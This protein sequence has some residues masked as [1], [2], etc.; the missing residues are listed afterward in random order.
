[1]AISIELNVESN[2]LL[3]PGTKAH[4]TALQ[5]LVQAGN[6]SGVLNDGVT[7]ALE[8]QI[9]IV[10]NSIAQDC[11]KEGKIWWRDSIKHKKNAQESRIYLT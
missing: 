6:D 11:Y 8:E 7:K 1:M 5:C 9:N 4:I 10:M 3:S 2:K